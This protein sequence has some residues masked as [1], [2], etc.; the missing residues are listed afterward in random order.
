MV[1]HAAADQCYNV[2]MP[3]PVKKNK[4]VKLRFLIPGIIIIALVTVLGVPQYVFATARCG[5]LPIIASK[6]AAAYSYTHPGDKYYA[7]NA[8][9]IYFCSSEEAEQ[10]GFHLSPLR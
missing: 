1:I 2:N 8:L 6:F 10:N 5:K 3:R 7:P 9:S 4:D